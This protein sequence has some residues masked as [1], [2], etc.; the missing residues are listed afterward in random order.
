MDD[1]SEGTEG[2]LEHLRIEEEQCGERLVLGGSADAAAA[3]EVR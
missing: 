1:L 2:P 3:G